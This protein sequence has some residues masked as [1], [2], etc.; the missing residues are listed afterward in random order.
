VSLQSRQRLK[1]TKNCPLLSSGVHN[2]HT[3]RPATLNNFSPQQVAD[4][5]WTS[6]SAALC[7]HCSA[8][9]PD[10]TVTSVCNRYRQDERRGK[11]TLPFCLAVSRSIRVSA[12]ASESKLPLFGAEPPRR[13]HHLPGICR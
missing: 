10:I 5:R 7:A 3:R 12:I 11:A 13:Y 6:S 4:R 2:P 8:S 1:S 9:L